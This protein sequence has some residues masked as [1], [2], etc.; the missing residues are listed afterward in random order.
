M[1]V[2]PEIDLRIGP[3]QNH[4]KNQKLQT[5]QFARCRIKQSHGEHVFIDTEY[6]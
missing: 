5:L 6:R 3:S 2:I 4:S 1:L